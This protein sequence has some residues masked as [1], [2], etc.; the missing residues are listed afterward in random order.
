[1]LSL[2]VRLVQVIILNNLTIY[3]LLSFALY[4]KENLLHKFM[5]AILPMS[6]HYAIL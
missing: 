6:M 3:Q 5:D 1:M 2:G 4:K